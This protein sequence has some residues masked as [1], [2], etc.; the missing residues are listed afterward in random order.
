MWLKQNNK[1]REWLADQCGVVKR[2][3]DGWLSGGKL[4][5]TPKRLVGFVIELETLKKQQSKPQ[6]RMETLVLQFTKE[7]WEEIQIITKH[8]PKPLAEV[9]E[10]T[11]KNIASQLLAIDKKIVNPRS[12]GF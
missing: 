6:E 7:E 12:K 11:L 8:Y 9:A 10:D 2:S 4:T 5:D 3:V 1:T